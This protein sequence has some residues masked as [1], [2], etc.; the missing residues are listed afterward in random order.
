VALPFV[1]VAHRGFAAVAEENSL[2]AIA[3]AL[4][5][6]CDKIELDVRRTRDGR[7]VLHHDSAETPG[8][9]ALEDALDLIAG[10]GAGIMVDLKEPAVA[11][12]VARL[13]DVHA[14]A[15]RVIASGKTDEVLLLKRLRPS[16]RAGRTWPPR[17][18]GGAAVV[19]GAAALPYRLTLPA[20]VRTIMRDFDV[21][22]ANYR[23]LSRSAIEAAHGA[24]HEVYAW[25]VDDPAT[26]ARLG[27]WGIDGVISDHPSSFGMVP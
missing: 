8:A 9:L 7:I 22:V 24:G 20:N 10:S 11:E 14:P 27:I 13:L 21:L 16:I 5:C 2:S 18:V 12:Q 15:A 25:T 1:R 6:G 26:I 23:V 19:R 4:R 3:G 17:S